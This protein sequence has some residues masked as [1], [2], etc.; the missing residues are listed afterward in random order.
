MSEIPKNKLNELITEIFL[1]WREVPRNNRGEINAGALRQFF[2]NTIKKSFDYRFQPLFKKNG[3]TPPSRLRGAFLLTVVKKIMEEM[4]VL[5]NL[6]G[7]SA[8]NEEVQDFLVFTRIYLLATQALFE[9]LENY[10]EK[11][12]K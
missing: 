5:P 7:S 10:G 11:N 6:S 12:E 8:G 2:I 4:V 1:M 3:D 9:L